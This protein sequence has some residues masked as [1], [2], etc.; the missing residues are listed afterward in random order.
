MNAKEN[1]Y[2]IIRY[3]TPERVL[4]APPAHHVAY[5]GA[6]HEGY[7]GGGHHVPV[8]TQ[9]TDVWGTV[10]H[11]ELEGVMGF[12]QYHPLH[13][14]QKDLK[15]YSWPDPD[16]ERICGRI[17]KQAET[18]D[19]TNSVLAGSHRETLWEKSYMLVGM[20]TLMCAFYT[21]PQAVRE[22][23][24]LV[25]DFQLSIA[26]HYLAVGVEMVNLS[27]DLGTQHGLLLSPD[28]L[29]SFLL[30]E[31]KRIF[32]FYKK[33]K[34]IINFHSCGCIQPLLKLFM[35]LG[36]N[37]LNPIQAS[38]NDLD[39]L[40]SATQGKMALMGGV[41][42][43]TIVH[44]PPE[45][46]RAEVAQRLCQLGKNGGYFCGPDQG[47]PW[48]EAHIEALHDAVEAMVHYPLTHC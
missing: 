1:A 44:G 13:N 31:Y 27:D 43:A 47:M 6:N 39:A 19:R 25:M 22:L 33:H 30:P 20:E 8:G 26:D 7:Q 10:W 41:S 37:I 2:H 15:S 40:R 36:V 16:D 42:S 23:F 24:H 29:D 3:G 45:A 14:L 18:W 21:E 17:Y 35:E 4:T 9:W 12:P 5:L 28:I 46:I 11:R 32:E 38:A 48:P 34:V